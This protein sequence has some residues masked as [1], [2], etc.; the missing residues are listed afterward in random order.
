MGRPQ[1]VKKAPCDVCACVDNLYNFTEPYGS[2]LLLCEWCYQRAFFF[3]SCSAKDEAVNIFWGAGKIGKPTAAFLIRFLIQNNVQNVLEYGT[4]LSTEIFSMVV[5][6]VVTLDPLK[7]HSD[8]YKRQAHL[9][10]VT[11][12]AYDEY[13]P[14]NIDLGRKFDFVFVDT[15]TTREHET[16]HGLAH[17]GRFLYLDDPNLGEQSFFPDENWV[18]VQADNPKFFV[19]T[20]LAA[21]VIL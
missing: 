8:L 15:Y 6:Q 2:E 10:N 11:F 14:I 19:R 4:G 20:E 1:I 9:K 17:A 16:K 18:R 13:K 3:L 12:F 21:G 5:P 7:R